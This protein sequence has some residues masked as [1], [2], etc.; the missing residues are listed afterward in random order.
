MQKFKTFLNLC[1]TKI[2]LYGNILV[3]KIKQKKYGGNKMETKKI[4]E[5]IVAKNFKD[6]T[7]E[8]TYIYDKAIW[9]QELNLLGN[10]HHNL[11]LVANGSIKNYL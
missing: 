9:K 2:I 6:L 4:I 11:V 5:S 3:D 10:V 1:L 8:E 7:E